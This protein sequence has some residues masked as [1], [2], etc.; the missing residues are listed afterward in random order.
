M[1]LF[2]ERN[3]TKRN[4]IHLRDIKTMQMMIMME[5]DDAACIQTPLIPQNPCF[6]IQN[7][8]GKQYPLAIAH[9]WRPSTIAYRP[10]VTYIVHSKQLNSNQFSL[11]KI[12]RISLMCSLCLLLLNKWRY[13]IRLKASFFFHIQNAQWN[14]RNY[15]NLCDSR[16]P[17]VVH[18]CEVKMTGNLNNCNV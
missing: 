15:S 18:L 14:K 12:H 2:A 1:K 4:R 5:M 7:C 10:I 8:N 11:I 6:I 3:K 9:S 13:I 16:L 17:F